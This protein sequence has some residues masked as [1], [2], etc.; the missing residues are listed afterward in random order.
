MVDDDRDDRQLF[1]DAFDELHV[2][3][4]ARAFGNGQDAL[5]H[6]EGTE[7]LPDLLFLDMYMPVMS[8]LEC[9][10]KIRADQRYAD[11]FVVIFSN[12]RDIEIIEQAFVMGA[13]AYVR[14]PDKFA[15]L[16][17]ILNK[18]IAYKSQCLTYELKQEYC[19]LSL[20]T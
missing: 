14:K 5:L 17:K 12:T 13:N 18:I 11:V 19:M 3:I 4:E 20:G 8:G 16:K 6:F 1:L 10:Q 2:N 15:T 7:T 9:L